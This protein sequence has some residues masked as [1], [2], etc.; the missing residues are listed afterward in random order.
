MRVFR[1]SGRVQATRRLHS[2]IAV[3]GCVSFFTMGGCEPDFDSLSSAYGAGGKAGLGGSRVEEGGMGGAL[4]GSGG[5]VMTGLGG[6]PMASRGGRPGSGGAKGSGGSPVSVGGAGGWWGGM[7][8]A[9][10]EAGALTPYGGRPAGSGGATGSGGTVVVGNG[11]TIST[12]GGASDSD[13]EGGAGGYFSGPCPKS[14]PI[15]WVS[16]PGYGFD[17]A[18]N[19]PVPVEVEVTT[20]DDL[21]AYAGSPQ[22]YTIYVS[23]EISVPALDVT[24]NKT[25]IGTDATATLNGGIRI[26]GTGTD[27]SAMVSNVT[28]KNLHINAATSN[29]STLA[30]EDDGITIAYAH[31][32]LVDH[33]DVFDAPG[34]AIDVTNGSDYVTIAW[35]RFRFVHGTRRTGARIGNSDANAAEDRGRLRVTLHHDYFMASVDQRM[36]RVRF[37]DVH[38]FDSYYS[39]TTNKYPV[40]AYCIAAA[41]ESRL[42]VQNNYFDDVQN[43]HV[44][45]SFVGG[46]A[47][48]TEPTAQM[49]VSD[50]TYIGRA[51]A[52]AGKLSGQGD[53]F[54]PPYTV[55]LEPANVILKNVIRQ[56][57]GPE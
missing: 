31:H 35:T 53:S 55:T 5:T 41:L 2:L 28:I 21:I 15:G 22:A 4:V 14:D 44:F 12:T 33:V 17:P 36:P 54:V 32:V 40:N 45:F 24:S 1:V 8:G 3:T 9:A 48:F 52:D 13:E 26:L 19:S 47:S 29:T 23:G 57:A 34:D 16:V 50:N 49:V 39:H 7:G 51:D 6:A 46:A 10:G 25:I 38:V 20:A 43:P 18:Q 42:L 37:G 56:C 11:G 30:D 27:P